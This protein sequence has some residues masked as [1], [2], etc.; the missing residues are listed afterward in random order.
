MSHYLTAEDLTEYELPAGPIAATL[1]WQTCGPLYEY[2]STPYHLHWLH[3]QS[4]DRPEWEI[5]SIFIVI[6]TTP[7]GAYA[8]VPLPVHNAHSL[9][10]NVR[11]QPLLHLW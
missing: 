7:A 10:P 1:F 5:L 9:Q 8:S 3:P 2:R 11:L 4:L 6:V